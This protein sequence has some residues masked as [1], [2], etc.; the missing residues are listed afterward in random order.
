MKLLITTFT[1][2]FISFGVKAHSLNGEYKCRTSP[3]SPFKTLVTVKNFTK[4]YESWEMGY[5]ELTQ[6]RELI[7]VRYD[8]PWRITADVFIDYIKL[9]EAGDYIIETNKTK[10][11]YIKL[12][13]DYHYGKYDNE[14]VIYVVREKEFSE[15]TGS[16]WVT[17]RS[18]FCEPQ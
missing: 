8:K 9:K 5:N 1:F 12:Q 2:M 14:G 3:Y 11:I 16:E 15:K 7:K 10:R 17:K 4:D 6:Q 18:V 13:H